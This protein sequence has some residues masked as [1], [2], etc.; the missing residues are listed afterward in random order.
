MVGV[1]GSRVRDLR[2]QKLFVLTTLIRLE[3]DNSPIMVKVLS[4]QSK[5]K[6]KSNH[7]IHYSVASLY[8]R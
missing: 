3:L 6:G 2:L 1:L 7:M 8:K 4:D 5:N